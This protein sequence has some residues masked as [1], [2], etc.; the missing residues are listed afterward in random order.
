MIN[1]KHR[2]WLGIWI[3][4]FV[5]GDLLALSS[6]NDF[7]SPPSYCATNSTGA[8]IFG[9]SEDAFILPSELKLKV[10]KQIPVD[11]YLTV[12]SDGTLFAH[13]GGYGL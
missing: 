3:F 12:K 8:V 2:L 10:K 11:Y 6:P 7:T 4:L 9:Y 13:S 5:S 1:F